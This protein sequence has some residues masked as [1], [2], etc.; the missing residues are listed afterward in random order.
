MDLGRLGAS[1][2]AHRFVQA[3]VWHSGD[4]FLYRLLDFYCCYRAYVRGKVTSIRLHEGPPP[5]QRPQLQRRATF[6]FALAAQ[7]ADRLTRPLLLLT[8]GLIASGK[9]TVAA[10]VAAALDLQ[11]YRSDQ[12]RKELAGLTPQ[13]SGRAA[14]GAG[15]YSAAATQRTYDGL[16]N[17]AYQALSQGHSVLLDA[18]FSKPSERQRM[19]AIA[20]EMGADYCLLECVAPEAVIRDR[21]R[22]REQA[23]ETM[24]D[25]RED[26]LGPFQHD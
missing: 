9:S 18:S 12:V 16:A 17:R 23:P 2:L 1:E 5:E 8:T 4:V 21:L 20:Q 22:E 14:Y 26:I 25:A 11:V 3:Y 6:Y 13:A 15:I 7:Y 19:V 10:G 24:S